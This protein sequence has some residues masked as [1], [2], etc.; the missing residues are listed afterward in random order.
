MYYVFIT[1]LRKSRNI[2]ILSYISV[3][4]LCDLLSYSRL[5]PRRSPAREIL[6]YQMC[7][8]QTQSRRLPRIQEKDLINL[9]FPSTC[10]WRMSLLSLMMYPTISGATNPI[11]LP[12]HNINSD[13]DQQLYVTTQGVDDSHDCAGEVVSDVNHGTLLLR[14]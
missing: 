12:Q 2:S 1:G 11:V 14:N 5:A 6:H 13:D 9:G 10:Q 8:P 3:K 7:T 4:S